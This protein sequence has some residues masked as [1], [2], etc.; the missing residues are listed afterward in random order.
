MDDATPL[1]YYT[2]PAANFVSDSFKISISKTKNL[3]QLF[4]PNPTLNITTDI[5]HDEL[6]FKNAENQTLIRIY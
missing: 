2:N 4:R 5:Y 3:D 6:S 1:N